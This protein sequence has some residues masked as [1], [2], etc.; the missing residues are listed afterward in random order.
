MGTIKQDFPLLKNNKKL[1]YLDNA[2]TTQKPS[3]VI[4]AIKEYYENYNSNAHRG[5]YD[6]SIQTT[7]KLGAARRIVQNY[8]CAE[9]NEV[10]FTKSATEGFNMLALAFEDNIGRWNNVIVSDHEHHSNFVPWQQACIR[11]KAKFIISDPKEIINKVDLRTSIVAIT[12]MSNVT[13]EIFNLEEIISKIKEKN[14]KTIVVVDATQLIAHKEVNVKKIGADFIVFS[15]HKIYGPFGVGV[16][17]GKLELLKTLRPFLY[18]GNMISQVKDTDSTW[19]D[20]PDKFEAGTIDSA[21]IIAF[22]KALEYLEKNNPNKLFLIEE[23]LKEYALTELRKIPEVKIIGHTSENSQLST[24]FGPVISIHVMDVHP[25]DLAEIANKENVCI[26]AGHHCAQQLM[27]K[28][29]LVATARISLSFY[30]TKKDV[31]A[32]I[33]AIKKARKIING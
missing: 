32:F 24:G 30:N 5:L 12:G 20:V 4:D 26:R 22:S 23:E 14:S 17:W 7:E 27:K 1:V 2:A 16:V 6:I 29:D 18:G 11:T 33:K 21:G 31:D 10:I 25:H 9:E 15:A 8:I 3:A 13:G 28:L 19:A